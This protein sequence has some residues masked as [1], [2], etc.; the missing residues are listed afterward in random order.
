MSNTS[1]EERVVLVDLHDRPIGEMG[2]LEAHQKGALH[3]AISVFVF[4]VQGEMLLQRRADHKYHS[5]GL[6]SNTCCSHPRV[7]EPVARAADRRL[8]E[9]MKL[10][11][12]LSHHFYFVYRAE[13]DRGLVE[14]ELDHVFIGI[15]D[16]QPDPDPDEVSEYR[17]ATVDDVRREMTEHAGDYTPWFRICF[18]RVVSAPRLK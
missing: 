11:C 6:W 1:L 12:D 8:W 15:C 5:G 3:R 4:N 9:E 2:K 18:E 10:A 16:D 14:H 13:F 7:G 17:W